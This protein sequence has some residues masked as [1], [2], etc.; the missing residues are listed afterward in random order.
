MTASSREAEKLVSDVKAVVNDAD[1]LIRA[2][3]SDLSDKTQEARKKL[4]E[5]MESAKAS[6]KKAE[7]KL[8]EQA[9][10]TDKVVRSHPYESIGIAAGV[11]L[12]VGLLLGRK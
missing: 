12:L 11:G 4:R 5:A 8:S 6:V 7:A 3:G 9:K 10:R 1:N 2:T